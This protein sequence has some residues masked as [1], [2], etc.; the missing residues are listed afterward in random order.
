MV[1]N[2]IVFNELLPSYPP[3]LNPRTLFDA[4]AL[5]RRAPVKS[6]K[7]FTPPFDEIVI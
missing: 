1:T 7:S 3:K 2:S 4:P 5:E 6:P